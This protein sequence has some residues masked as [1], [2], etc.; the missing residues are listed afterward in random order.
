MLLSYAVLRRGWEVWEEAWIGFLNKFQTQF[1]RQ[2][3]LLKYGWNG[4]QTN[5]N[6]I[7]VDIHFREN[8]KKIV[9]YL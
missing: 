9:R 8:G 6:N 4:F 7:E 3:E 2:K 1:S 5:R